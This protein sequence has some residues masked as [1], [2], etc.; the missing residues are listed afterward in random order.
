MHTKITR[1]ARTRD[2]EKYV[3]QRFADAVENH[4]MTVENDNGVFRCVHF[5]RPDSN[6]Y[7]FRLITWPGY[8]VIAGDTE[9][10]I[11]TRLRDMF[12]FFR[13][14]N[15]NPGYWGEKA[16]AVAKHGGLEVFSETAYKEA[17]RSDVLMHIEGRQLSEQR[18]IVREAGNWLFESSPSNIQDAVAVAQDFFCPITKQHP[19][20]DFWDHNLTEPSFGFLFACHAIRWGIEQYDQQKAQ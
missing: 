4:K 13:G 12:E 7:S 10:F 9:D 3:A 11:F 18:E 16:T 1:S 8:L 20:H 2:Q 17:I 5:S 15:I 14:D 19:F 6:N